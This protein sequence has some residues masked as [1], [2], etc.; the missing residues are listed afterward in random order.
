M[1]EEVGMLRRLYCFIGWH[2]WKWTLPGN[3]ILHLN[4]S[5]PNH[6]ACVHCGALYEKCDNNC[7]YTEKY[8]FVPEADCPVH[9][10]N[11]QDGS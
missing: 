11:D 8:G 10:I 4:A 9:D 5:P 7:H 2:S 6:A 1:S 3:G